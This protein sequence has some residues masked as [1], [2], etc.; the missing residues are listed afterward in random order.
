M[1]TI[2]KTGMLKIKA[3]LIKLTIERSISKK[4]IYKNLL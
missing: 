4:S 1:R 3:P 2:K